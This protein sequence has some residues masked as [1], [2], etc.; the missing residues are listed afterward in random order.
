MLQN[1][2]SAA[3]VIGASRVNNHI[4][5]CRINVENL[6]S[7]EKFIINMTASAFPRVEDFEKQYMIAENTVLSHSELTD[8]QIPGSNLIVLPHSE[9]TDK[10]IP[11][12]LIVLTHLERAH[13]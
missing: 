9:L 5:F 3:V 11:G 10:K 7:E 13:R 1:L 4:I 6:I 2:L 8:K 12:N